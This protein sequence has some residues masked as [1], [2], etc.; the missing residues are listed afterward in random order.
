[1]FSPYV[2]N[3]EKV[4]VYKACYI[5]SDF[6]WTLLNGEYLGNQA[7]KEFYVFKWSFWQKFCILSCPISSRNTTGS[8]TFQTWSNQFSDWLNFRKI[9]Y[10][11]KSRLSCRNL[12]N[13]GV[14]NNFVVEIE[15]THATFSAK[16]RFGYPIVSTFWVKSSIL[17]KFC[18]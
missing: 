16:L 18:G 9:L 6:A 15:E 12:R 13:F 5:P 14:V 8:F 1:M 17:Q 7:E 10:F 2:N 11:K 3:C 4:S